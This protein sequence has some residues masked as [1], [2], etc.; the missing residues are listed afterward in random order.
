MEFVYNPK[1]PV[2]S[3]LRCVVL[4]NIELSCC[5]KIPSL[6]LLSFR[7]PLLV[8]D[9]LVC[10]NLVE[11]KFLGIS[12]RFYFLP[13]NMPLLDVGKMISPLFWDD[14]LFAVQV[15]S[16]RN[17]SISVYGYRTLIVKSRDYFKTLACWR[18]TQFMRNSGKDQA[19][20]KEQ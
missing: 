18:F 19:G 2:T 15:G 1:Y 12:V 9:H 16:L 20:I 6:L 8:I 3:Y 10:G 17:R 7:N 14:M 5:T 4:A 11:S 13:V